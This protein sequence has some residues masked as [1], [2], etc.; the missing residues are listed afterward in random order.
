MNRS[1]S[2][3]KSV[4]NVFFLNRF[5]V[6]RHNSISL[7]SVSLSSSFLLDCLF[8]FFGRQ[9]SLSDEIIF[10]NFAH[11]DSLSELCCFFKNFRTFEP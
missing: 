1:K 7:S 3:S 10:S 9:N 11:I 8:A 2:I 5:T 4:D 6:L